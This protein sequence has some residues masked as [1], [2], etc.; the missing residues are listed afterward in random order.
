MSQRKFARKATATPR[1]NLR[2][3]SPP[4]PRRRRSRFKLPANLR[5]QR[6]AKYVPELLQYEEDVV[7]GAVR[8][9]ASAAPMGKV[10]VA[11][12]EKRWPDRFRRKQLWWTL[13]RLAEDERLQTAPGLGLIHH[14]RTRPG[15]MFFSGYG[16]AKAWYERHKVQGDRE[17]WLRGGRAR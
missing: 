5:R 1:P 11:R 10:T 14:H 17:F 8:E 4:K 15:N 2:L 7:L 6:K 12:L 3:V 13:L 9:L 16:R